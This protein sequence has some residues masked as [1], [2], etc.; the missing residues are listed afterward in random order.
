MNARVFRS[1]MIGVAGAI[2]VHLLTG[3]AGDY[4]GDDGTVEQDDLPDASLPEECGG[5]ME[6]PTCPD[7]QE[8]P[9]QVQCPEVPLPEEC[10][11]ET[12]CPEPRDPCDCFDWSKD[13]HKSA[14]VAACIKD[15]IG[16]FGLCGRGYDLKIF[17]E[18]P[19]KPGTWRYQKAW[20]PRCE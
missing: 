17:C 4:W 15:V 10:P 2:V 11:P 20:I 14:E 16:E 1:I 3:C 6:C 12:Q 8:C 18:N 7:Q 9:P 13:D 19:E 5:E